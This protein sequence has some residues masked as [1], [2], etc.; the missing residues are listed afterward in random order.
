MSD[1]KYY[2]IE[3]DPPDGPARKVIA[4]IA[5]GEDI[6]EEIRKLVREAFPPRTR[7]IGEPVEVPADQVPAFG[8]NLSDVDWLKGL[9]D[10]V[11]FLPEGIAFKANEFDRRDV[12]FAMLL[13]AIFD[14]PP[15]I[16][17]TMEEARDLAAN[18][19]RERMSKLN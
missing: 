6:M 16:A 18:A 8:S 19:R 5:H 14:G 13:S 17:G 1:P 3:I 10:R 9:I 11:E 7:I 12:M 15:H 2:T 4:R